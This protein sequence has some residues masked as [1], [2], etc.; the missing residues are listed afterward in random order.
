MIDQLINDEWLRKLV[1]NT[2][3]ADAAIIVRTGSLQVGPAGYLRD[4]D[5][6]ASIGS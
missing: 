5:V 3:T 1:S 2:K 4:N 6:A